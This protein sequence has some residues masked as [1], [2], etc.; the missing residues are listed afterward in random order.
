MFCRGVVWRIPPLVV[1]CVTESRRAESELTSWPYLDSGLTSASPTTSRSWPFA[2]GFGAWG[3]GGGVRNGDSWGR[4]PLQML[5]WKCT[6]SDIWPAACGVFR[7]SH[8]T[9][10]A[11]ISLPRRRVQ[12]FHYSLFINLYILHLV[13]F[14][15]QSH[16]L[17]PVP[18]FIPPL[19]VFPTIHSFIFWPALTLYSLF[20]WI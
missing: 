18:P 10:T 15:I 17:S 4:L 16:F 13:P 3:G 7:L 8:T 2:S 20:L 19:L 12:L 14:I 9:F 5:R 11:L 6:S 1:L